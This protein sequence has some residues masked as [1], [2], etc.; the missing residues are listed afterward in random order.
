MPN[1]RAYRLRDRLLNAD[2]DAASLQTLLNTSPDDYSAFCQLSQTLYA[3]EPLANIANGFSA[4]AG[5]AIARGLVIASPDA[6]RALANSDY[7]T[8]QLC[9]SADAVLILAEIL[10]DITG[11]RFS[12][13]FEYDYNYQRIKQWVNA[14]GSKLKR[15]V[16][17]SSGTWT[18]PASVLAW[19]AS[20]V[21]SGGGGQN[22]AGGGGGGG[23]GEIKTLNKNT[24][25]PSS[26]L[27]ITIPNGG[28]S[29]FPGV[30]GSATTI[31]AELSAAG[32][33]GGG[34][35]GGGGG[36]TT[37]GNGWRD[38]TEL[39]LINA[40]WQCRTVSQKGGNGGDPGGMGANGK[41]GFPNTGG[42]GSFDNPA[43]ASTSGSGYGGGGGG[44]PLISGT[45]PSAAPAPPANTGAGGAGG[46]GVARGGASGVAVVHHLEA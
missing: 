5:S 32:G 3:F 24:S 45:S 2:I 16:F 21:G 4:V 36:G 9:K 18:A 28:T 40:P 7:A 19:S 27:S 6:L 34:A 22:N 42:L 26:N 43:T 13:W 30:N 38:I 8:E 46:D 15:Q 39:D 37:T 44:G 17:N 11:E 35:P 12:H 25:I 41:D 31:G 33:S 29:G 10:K 20:G 23:G 14:Y 1:A